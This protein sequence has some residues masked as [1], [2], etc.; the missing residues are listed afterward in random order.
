MKKNFTKVICV[1]MVLATLVCIFAACNDKGSLPKIV[2]IEASTLPRQY[3]VTDEAIDLSGGVLTVFYDNKTT[4]T[5][6]MTD[7][8]VTLKHAGTAI[9]Y[10][11]KNMTLTYKGVTLAIP[12]SV[13]TKLVEKVSMTGDMPNKYAIG[14]KPRLKDVMFKVK[15]KDVEK[16]DDIWL[17]SGNLGGFNENYLFGKGIS[18]SGFDTTKKGD[19]TFVLK[20]LSEVFE[21]KYS[22]VETDW[23][24][25]AHLS[26]VDSIETNYFVNEPLNIGASKFVFE[27]SIG[28]T[29]EVKITS[30]MITGFDT[31]TV[32]T[33]KIY[34][35]HPDCEYVIS[36]DYTVSVAENIE[37]SVFIENYVANYDVGDSLDF[38]Y[39]LKNIF[40]KIKKDGIYYKTIDA[41]DSDIVIKCTN[42]NLL[43]K[44][45]R[46]VLNT[47]LGMT[48]NFEVTYRGHYKAKFEIVVLKKLANMELINFETIKVDYV[49]GEAFN[50]GTAQIKW[51]YDDGTWI[52][53]DLQKQYDAPKADRIIGFRDNKAVDVQSFD[54]T[55]GKHDKEFYIAVAPNIKTEVLGR[56]YINYTVK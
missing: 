25:G 27:Y 30:D 9:P 31:T 1:A 51:F 11:T 24:I 21:I 44:G 18:I 55:I 54:M 8:A 28:T 48:Y 35:K 6:S 22:V 19:F 50:F 56:W 14:G 37:T 29:K 42:E 4:E 45:L 26:N 39:I 40:I 16:T 33:R 13:N 32:G 10:T 52:L 49:E 3:Y 41:T 7:S 2:R 17:T 12:Y 36:K 15:Y 53:I 43:N 5:V 23:I 47:K 20:Y 38:D 34:F 46:E